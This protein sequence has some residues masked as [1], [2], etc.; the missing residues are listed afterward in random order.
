M[1]RTEQS[2]EY[3]LITRCSETNILLQLA[4]HNTVIVVLKKVGSSQRN[5]EKKTK[6]HSPTSEL[7]FTAAL[8]SS[9]RVEW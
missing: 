5:L 6:R 2:Q 3:I 4:D 1:C 8:Q 9:T 7:S